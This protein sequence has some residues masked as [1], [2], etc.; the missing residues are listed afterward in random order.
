MGGI[1]LYEALLVR[2]LKADVTKITNAQLSQT[3]DERIRERLCKFE[4]HLKGVLDA[5]HDEWNLEVQN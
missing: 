3:V 2:C 4:H 5:F 1:K